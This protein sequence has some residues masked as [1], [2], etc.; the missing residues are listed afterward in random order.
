MKKHLFLTICLIVLGMSQAM[1]QAAKVALQHNGNVTLYNADELQKALDVSVDGDTIYLN[2]GTFSG[3]ITISKRVSVIGAGENTTISGNVTISIYG[4]LNA[5]LLDALVVTGQLS[6]NL[7]TNG[8][9]VR[10]CKFINGVYL[11][12]GEIE[13]GLFDRC[14]ILTSMYISTNVRSLN[15]VNSKVQYVRGLPSDVADVCFTHCNVETTSSSLKAT[16]IDSRVRNYYSSYSTN[17]YFVNCLLYETTNIVNEI[18]CKYCRFSYTDGL[19][20]MNWSGVLSNPTTSDGTPVGI[21]GGT[22]PYTLVPSVPTV[23]NYSL[24][25]NTTTKRLNVN[26]SVESK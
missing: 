2:E 8:L 14:S 19:E 11:T 24:N 4:T 10:K 26:I 13:N 9:V 7:S 23:T 25:V 20:D 3:G 22:T 18:N 21:E 15:V 6:S 17:C 1:A 16:F 5:R 12:Q